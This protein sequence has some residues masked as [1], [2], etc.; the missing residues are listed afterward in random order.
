[1]LYYGTLV[2]FDSGRAGTALSVFSAVS[3]FLQG[4]GSM[5]EPQDRTPRSSV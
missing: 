1:M 5:F 2:V 3:L 4:L